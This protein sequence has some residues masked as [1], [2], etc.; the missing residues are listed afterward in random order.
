[1]LLNQM[2]D[3]H[4]STTKLLEFCQMQDLHFST[5]KLLEFC[6]NCEKTPIVPKVTKVAQPFFFTSQKDGQSL[7]LCDAP[8]EKNTASTGFF[9]DV[10]L[11]TQRPFHIYRFCKMGASVIQVSN[12]SGLFR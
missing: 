8:L 3:L 7:R 4:F 6:S 11:V 9:G 1:M 5:T 12:L 2:Q 10:F